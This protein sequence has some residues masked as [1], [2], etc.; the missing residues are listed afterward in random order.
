LID[1]PR[2][3]I[4]KMQIQGT[5]FKDEFNRTLMLR[6]VNLAGSSKIPAGPNGAT[7]VRDGFFDHRDVSF[8]GRPFP[9]NEADEH[10]R[11]LKAWGLTFLRFLITWEA[12]EHAG[13]GQYDDEYIDYV[14]AVVEIAH[15]HG[16]Q[17]FIDPHQDVWSR[18][19]G[20]DGAP[21][22]TLELAGMDLT[23]LQETGAAIVHALHGDPF[24][25]MI[26][27][28]NAHKLATATM[29]AL[30][31]AGNDLAP[32][33]CMQG[34]PAQEFLQRH[35][36]ASMRRLAHALRGLPN[37]VGFDTM[38]E[39]MRGYMGIDDLNDCCGRPR[40]GDFPAPLQAM[41]LASGIPQEVGVWEMDLRGNRKVNSRK[42]NPKGLR[43]WKEGYECIW[44][45]NG[46]WDIGPSGLPRLLRP[47]H[48][49]QVDG[50]QVDFNQ[51]YYK[52]FANRYAREIRAEL[53]DAVIFIETEPSTP[54]P[55]WESEDAQ[56]IVYAPHWY[57]AATLVL[58]KFYPFV[59]ADYHTSK[60]VIGPHAIA[61]SFAAQLAR[62]K[63]ESL[64]SLRS[65]PVLIGEFGVPFDLDGKRSYRSGNFTTQIQ[66]LDRSLRAMEANLLSCTIW[67]YTPDNTNERGDLWND[68]DLSIF[69]LDQQTDPGDINSGGRALQAVLRPY[70]KATA[71]QLVSLSFDMRKHRMHFAFIPDPEISAPTEIYVPTY[72][73]PRGVRV[74]SPLG[75][76]EYDPVSQTLFYWP[77]SPGDIHTIRILPI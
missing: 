2:V 75:R 10:F 62:F 28:T 66:A 45:Q 17:L 13:P 50:L 64:H 49:S 53:P 5:D 3:D 60:L 57:D 56:N 54:S 76:H 44:R 73:Y 22:W 77:T 34:E 29:F 51:D 32:N 12:I 58:K 70:P 47:F 59:A 31:F 4:K 37:V 40:L 25:R 63:A 52:P 33:T 16:I 61:R 68:E 14:R 65:A 41:L 30:F 26:W 6:G 23:L 19:T 55:R 20:G 42:V 11:R 39:P 7:Y 18:F 36:I 8:V 46:V 15:Q 43:L 24:P 1:F 74:E 35:Y 71:G 69:S 21:G 9:L 38:N 48:F 67:N 72:H 27:P